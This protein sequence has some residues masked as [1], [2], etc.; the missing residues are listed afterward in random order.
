MLTATLKIINKASDTSL[1]LY[2]EYLASEV[3]PLNILSKK[4]ITFTT[5][6]KIYMLYLK[7]KKKEAYCSFEDYTQN[8]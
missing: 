8:K 3:K 1:K 7:K 4:I 6:N 5:W 2:C